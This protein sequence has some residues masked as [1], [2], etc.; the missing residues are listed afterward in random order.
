MRTFWDGRAHWE[1]ARGS[2]TQAITYCEKDGDFMEFGVRPLTQAEKGD[3]NKRRYEEAW[4]SA[5]EGRMDDIDADLRIRHY[6][7]LKRICSDHAL[8]G[9]IETLPHVTR[10]EWFYGESGTGKSRTARERWPDAYL[11]MCN[12]WWDGYTGQEVVI[13]GGLRCEACG[14][15][16]SPQ[17]LGGHLPILDGVQGW[18]DQ[19]QAEADCS[20]EQLPS[21]PDLGLGWGPATSIAPVQDYAILQP[22]GFGCDCGAPTWDGLGP[23]EHEPWCMSRVALPWED[24]FF[25]RWLEETIGDFQ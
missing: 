3:K 23:V 11:K 15:Y 18:G 25:D 20:D 22:D 6:S 16:P 17:D 8:A 4:E 1:I 13:L 2:A 21:G 19:D 24:V 7:T 14:A 9:N 10:M 12:K 5:V